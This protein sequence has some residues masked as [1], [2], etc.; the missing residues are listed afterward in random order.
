MSTQPM[1]KYY[2][3]H[4]FSKFET[5]IQA[6]DIKEKSYSAKQLVSSQ[7]ETLRYGYFIKSGVLKLSIGH[8]CGNEKTLALFGPGSIF[9][10]G[11]N[12]HHYTMEYAMSEEAFTDLLVYEFE[13]MELKKIALKHP[14]FSLRM[15]E[16]YCDFTSFL[17]YEISS[18]SNEQSFLK[19]C[20]LIYALSKTGLYSDNFIPMTQY[21]IASFSGFS[22]IQVAR[23][24]QQLK[25]QQVIETKRN[26]FYIINL[27]LLQSLCSC[28]A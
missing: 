19:I 12:E 25:E 6:Y 17:F 5:L 14:E 28:D 22:K 20:N 24:Y 3:E 9:P 23:V 7:N 8:E 4:D 26:G 21:E 16:H 15:L 1:R 18:L 2:F 11:V 27:S 13:Y 10:I